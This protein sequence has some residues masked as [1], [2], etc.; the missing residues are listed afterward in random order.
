MSVE[1]LDAVGTVLLRIV[2]SNLSYSDDSLYYSLVLE[3]DQ[4]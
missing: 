4:L 1:T 3:C 2:V